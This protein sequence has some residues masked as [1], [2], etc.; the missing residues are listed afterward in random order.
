[1]L[2]FVIRAFLIAVFHFAIAIG[3]IFAWSNETEQHSHMTWQSFGYAAGSVAFSTPLYQIPAARQRLQF[4]VGVALNSALWGV[5]LAIIFSRPRRLWL[6]L[7]FPILW[8]G[9]LTA[10][11]NLLEERVDREWNARLGSRVPITQRFPHQNANPLS[12]RVDQSIES[13]SADIEPVRDSIRKYLGDEFARGDDRLGPLPADVEQ[14][15]VARRFDIDALESA[16][17]AEPEWEVDLTANDQ[18]DSLRYF[19][20]QKMIL[21]DALAAARDGDVDT[22]RRRLDAAQRLVVSLRTRPEVVAVVTALA[23]AENHLGVARKLGI[24]LPAFDAREPL[25]DAFQAEAWTDQFLVRTSRFDPDWDNRNEV[26]RALL[27]VFVRPY[28]RICAA[29]AASGQLRNAVI[30]RNFPRCVFQAPKY[31]DEHPW[32]VSPIEVLSAATA[33]SRAVRSNRLLLD[34]EGTQRI[35]QAQSEG[36]ISS[37][38]MCTDRSWKFDAGVVHLEPPLP[39]ASGLPAKGTISRGARR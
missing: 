21:A 20:A 10:A 2:R 22:A 35:A 7:L 19:W 6:L 27:T 12:R 36:T 18:L 14:R 32:L 37:T 9:G 26:S 8:F 33:A 17:N 31:P 16:L 38:S 15:L 1:M 39:L 30:I 25:V 11:A 4:L 3:F 34:V 5:L 23:S 28:A 13:L 29:R 24:A